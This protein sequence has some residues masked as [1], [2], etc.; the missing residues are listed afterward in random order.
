ME[1]TTLLNSVGV[2][3]FEPATFC[4]QSRRATRL[5]HTPFSVSLHDARPGAAALAEVDVVGESGL[6]AAAAAEQ[7]RREEAHGRAPGGGRERG[8]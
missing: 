2:T 5:R 3:G 1:G 4:S 6:D 7:E 8:G